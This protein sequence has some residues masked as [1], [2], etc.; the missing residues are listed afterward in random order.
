M[1]KAN[2]IDVKKR[3]SQEHVKKVSEVDEPNRQRRKKSRPA[4]QRSNVYQRVRCKDVKLDRHIKE[5][6]EGEV[7]KISIKGYCEYN[8][9]MKQNSIEH[10]DAS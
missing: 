8:G 5:T 2:H 4:G 3:A 6:T 7:T 1:Y 9:W 10:N